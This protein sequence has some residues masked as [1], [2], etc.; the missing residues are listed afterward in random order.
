MMWKQE[1]F[2][3]SILK[4]HFKRKIGKKISTKLAF[5]MFETWKYGWNLFENS[6]T[7]P[8]NSLYLEDLNV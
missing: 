7:F 6:T 5:Q 3:F 2:G 1:K 8:Q 4:E